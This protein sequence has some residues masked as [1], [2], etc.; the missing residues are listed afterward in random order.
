MTHTPGPWTLEAGRSIV[1][2]SGSFYLSYGSDKTGKPNFP[3]FCELD[4]NARL[5]AAAPEM[6]AALNDIVSA[7]NANCGD[8]LANAIQHA[9]TVIA[10]AATTPP[11]PKDERTDSER[12]IELLEN[13]LGLRP[14]SYSG[15]G[16]MG[17][18]CVGVS[19]HHLDE[20]DG[21]HWEGKRTDSLG[22]GLIVYW[23]SM[24]WPAG[25]EG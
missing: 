19:I 7:S 13:S 18:E 4:A 16:M 11:A 22:R 24:P 3:N 23:P 10:K 8:S 20:L 15:R 1:T 25:R 9:M 5:I 21:L 6:L 14:R 12:L 2:P 17:K